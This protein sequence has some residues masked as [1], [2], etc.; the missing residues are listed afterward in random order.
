MVG[1]DNA[2]GEQ[3][4][5]GRMPVRSQ[6]AGHGVGFYSRA[7]DGMTGGSK[8]IVRMPTL[9]LGRLANGQIKERFPY[10]DLIGLQPSSQKPA[11]GQHNSLGLDLSLKFLLTDVQ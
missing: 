6:G 11:S 2:G 3:L 10:A 1:K 4:V 9:S 8:E 7:I 5:I